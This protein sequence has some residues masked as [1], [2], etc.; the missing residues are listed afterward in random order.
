MSVTTF[1]YNAKILNSQ[2]EPL[3]CLRRLMSPLDKREREVTMPLRAYQAFFK[4]SSHRNGSNAT[5]FYIA[6]HTHK[7]KQAISPCARIAQFLW[8]DF[9]TIYAQDEIT[10]HFA[11]LKR[12]WLRPRLTGPCS[13]FG[14]LFVH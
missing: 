11:S 14:A 2:V 5:R 9:G 4:A 1:L 6:S 3:S 12:L 13:K 10:S 8:K 7:A